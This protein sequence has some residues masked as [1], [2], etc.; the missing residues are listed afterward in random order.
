MSTGFLWSLG[1]N[2]LGKLTK[3]KMECSYEAE[4]VFEAEVVGIFQ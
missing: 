1:I 4:F 3:N 2:P